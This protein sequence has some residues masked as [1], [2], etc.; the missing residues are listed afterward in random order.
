MTQHA[1]NQCKKFRYPNHTAKFC[2]QK[3]RKQRGAQ[4]PSPS[5]QK[6]SYVHI[7]FHSPFITKFTQTIDKKH[8]KKEIIVILILED[9]KKLN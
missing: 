1:R 7:Q 4:F 6:N 3:L 5:Q 2:L 8:K 9:N